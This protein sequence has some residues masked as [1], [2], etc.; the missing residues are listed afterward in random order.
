MLFCLNYSKKP[1]ERVASFFLDLK[2]S[3]F[4]NKPN[5]RFAN[6]FLGQI[7][8]MAKEIVLKPL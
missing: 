5:E 1:I 8:E 3:Q 4:G 2:L 7:I 6:F